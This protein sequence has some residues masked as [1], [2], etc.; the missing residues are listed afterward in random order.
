MTMVLLD[1]KG[2]GRQVNLLDDPWWFRCGFQKLAALRAIG[3]VMRH[4]TGEAFRWERHAEMSCVSRL[5]ANGTLRRVW[6][7]R[8]FGGLDNVGRW[9]FGGSRRILA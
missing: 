1:G 8:R 5:G 4:R 9:R 2:E 3:Q 7:R 6:I